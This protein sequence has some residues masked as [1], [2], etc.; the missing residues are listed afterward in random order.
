M[1]GPSDTHTKSKPADGRFYSQSTQ[2]HP[3]NKTEHR[4]FCTMACALLAPASGPLL[5]RGGEGLWPQRYRV[6]K[7]DRARRAH[8]EWSTR[9]SLPMNQG[10]RA[11][12]TIFALCQNRQPG[13]SGKDPGYLGSKGDYAR[14]PDRLNEL[15]QFTISHFAD[16]SQGRSDQGSLPCSTQPR[17][18]S[19]TPAS[20]HH[21]RRLLRVPA[22]GSSNRR[23]DRRA[24]RS[25]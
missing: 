10:C 18:P 21:T 14:P 5:L 22:A 24:C 11:I 6:L 25:T 20:S 15:C 1:A 9:G 2:K 19:Q 3:W 16:L 13:K 4:R 17:S 23:G 8:I 12:G 7:A